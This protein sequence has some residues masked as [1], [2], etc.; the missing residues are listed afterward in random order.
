MN[1]TQVVIKEGSLQKRNVEGTQKLYRRSEIYQKALDL[2]VKKGYD[3]TPM[4]MISKVLGMSQANLYYYCSSKENLLYQIHIDDLRKRF[5][6]ILDEVEKLFDP[7]ERLILFLRKFTLMCTSSPASRVL[8]HEVRS[9]NR[10]HQNEIL[11]IWRR[12]YELIREAIKELQQTGKARKYR[13]SFLTF[14][15]VGMAF[16]IVYWFDYSRQDNAEELADILVQTF[17]NGLLLPG[18]EKP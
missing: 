13:E 11:S 12:A 16:W 5:I 15:G 14:L 10:S 1:N 7:K 2:F 3:A 17:L 4:S 6:P 8:V 9:L 18:N